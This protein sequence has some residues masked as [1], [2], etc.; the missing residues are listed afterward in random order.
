[1]KSY[2]N[3]TDVNFIMFG[4]LFGVLIIYSCES[5]RNK[6]VFCNVLLGTKKLN[7]DNIKVEFVFPD[8]IS[9]TRIIIV[10]T[11]SEIRKTIQLFLD[12][13]NFG[14]VTFVLRCSDYA[15]NLSEKTNK[16]KIK[17]FEALNIIEVVRNSPNKS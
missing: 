11:I 7:L 13:F 16:S 3:G 2:D 5:I 6:L 12:R 14:N 17:L 4:F 9:N 8:T 10:S 1:M 15:R